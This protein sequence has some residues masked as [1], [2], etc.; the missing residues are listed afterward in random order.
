MKFLLSLL[1]LAL[2]FTATDRAATAQTLI[3][4]GH[5]VG[6]DLRIPPNPASQPLAN[7]L[8]VIEAQHEADGAKFDAMLLGY[9]NLSITIHPP[10]PK[11][12]TSPSIKIA[13]CKWELFGTWP[14]PGPAPPIPD[15][16]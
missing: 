12:T 13:V 15:P 7:A 16:E 3:A 5:G 11:T 2:V 4:S 10:K 6:I 14:G 8:A 9:T 1:V